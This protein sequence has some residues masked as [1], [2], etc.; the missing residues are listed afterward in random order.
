MAARQG[1]LGER[2]AAARLKKYG[3]KI[4]TRNWR[5]PRD[6]RD[7]IDLVCLDGE[8]LVF[9]EVKARAAGA[10]VSGYHA[11]DRRKKTALRRA[12][13]TY[14]KALKPPDRPKTFRFDVV[15]VEMAAE[16]IVRHFEN[17][18]LFEKEYGF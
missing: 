13:D 9:V 6:Q 14:L 10:L 2:L 5:S 15:E 11:I 12:I 7:E 17:V 4:I 18:P 3:L 16:P 8:V 1:A